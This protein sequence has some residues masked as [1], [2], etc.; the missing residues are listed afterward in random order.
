MPC[1]TK[2][3]GDS[4]CKCNIHSVWHGRFDTDRRFVCSQSGQK[5]WIFL[6]QS[7]EVR[8]TI[9]RRKRKG[10]GIACFCPIRVIS[11]RWCELDS[12]AVPV[13]A[14][15]LNLT[16]IVSEWIRD[17]VPHLHYPKIHKRHCKNGSPSPFESPLKDIWLLLWQGC[18]PGILPSQIDH[19]WSY[20]MI[21][22]HR[23][24]RAWVNDPWIWSKDWRV[25]RDI[26]VQ[27]YPTGTN[28]YPS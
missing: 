19:G 4:A 27:I 13:F 25:V 14:V 11:T 16:N 5:G 28:P 9:W 15:W 22:C 17:E 20:K 26:H 8:Q 12:I 3:L 23:Y 7:T 18:F 2:F 1:H 6:L 24:V 21:Y 10:K